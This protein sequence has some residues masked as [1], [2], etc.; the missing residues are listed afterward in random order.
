MRK[1]YFDTTEVNGCISA[2]STEAEVI[3]A[4]TTIY[5]MSIK[6]KNEEYQRY[7]NDYDIHF[8]FDDDIPVLSFYTVPQVDILARDSEGGFIGTVS[9][10]ADLE[11][12][13]PICYVNNHQQCFLIAKNG[14]EFLEIVDSWKQHL[15]PYSDIVFYSSK[16][17]AEKELEFIEVP[18]MKMT[19]N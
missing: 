3:P 7:A 2:F 18:K 16:S 12:D 5:S 19:K 17:E 15:E 6:D 9:Q 8:I 4:G 14:K 1:I 10:R 11:S 13:A